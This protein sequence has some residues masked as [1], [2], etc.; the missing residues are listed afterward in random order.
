MTPF[1]VPTHKR[2]QD[3]TRAV[4]LTNEKPSLPV[5]EDKT[6]RTACIHRYS[7]QNTKLQRV[8]QPFLFRCSGRNMDGKIRTSTQHFADVWL[9]VHVL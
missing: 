6:E 9:D 3:M 5:P 1:P 4:I 2:L 7:G 8:K